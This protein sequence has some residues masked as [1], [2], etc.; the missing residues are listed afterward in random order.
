MFKNSISILPIIFI[1]FFSI[2]CNK[3]STNMN[4]NT[5]EKFNQLAENYINGFLKWRPGF[6]VNLGLHEYDG[7]VNNLSKLAL[8]DEMNRLKFYNDTLS[9]FDTSYLSYNN[10]IDLRI[11]QNS[12]K[13]ELYRFEIEKEY[14]TNPI[15][16]ASAIEINNYIKRDYTLLDDRAKSII[17]YLD[18]SEVIYTNARLNLQD[19]LSEVYIK[20]AIQIL[21]ETIEF[22]KSDVSKF[23]NQIKRISLKNSFQFSVLRATEY[24]DGFY[25]FLKDSKLPA[26]KKDFAIGGDNYKKMLE[27]E[28]VFIE[29]DKLL[30]IGLNELKKT[31]SEFK[32][33]AKNIDA[34]KSPVD[35]FLSIQKE[36]PTEESLISDTKKNLDNLKQFL[37][38]KKIITIPSDIQL[39][40]EETPLNSRSFGFASMDTPGPFEKVKDAFYYVTPVEKNWTAKEKEEWLTSFNYY[41]TDIVSIHEAYPG[42]FVQNTVLNNSSASKIKKIFG[43]YAFSE[44]WAHYTEQI[45]MDE[46]F[47]K[48][49]DEKKWAKY[50]LAQ[51]DEAL[52]RLCRFVVSIKMHCYGMTVDEATKFFMENCYYE[53]KPAKQEAIRGTYDAGYL[54]YSLGKLMVLK[55]REDYKKQ[56]GSQ[57]ELKKFNDEVISHGMP[58]I[59]LL[60]EIMLKDKNIWKDIL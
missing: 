60:R 31:Q 4:S 54:Y 51:L 42:H 41:T 47:A 55:L 29:P 1:L 40:V 11:L 3:S 22:L 16:Y 23:A 37:T 43:S 56:E 39:K 27:C 46:G 57:Y 13:N 15:V 8:D 18:K 59:P 32:E 38:D 6:G 36:H 34:N 44:G 45:M 50:K 26:A 7:K 25:L 20:T 12:V 28:M 58:P 10:K 19:T 33:V 48:N 24:L 30:E 52:L 21:L 49:G 53:E 5:D 17:N 14:L 2:N 35:V 9:K